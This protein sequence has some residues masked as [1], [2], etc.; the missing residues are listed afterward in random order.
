MS[1]QR[2][3]IDVMMP[4]STA[5]AKTDV[6]LQQSNRR[7]GSILPRTREGVLREGTSGS[8]FLVRTRASDAARVQ[9]LGWTAESDASPYLRQPVDILLIEPKQH[10]SVAMQWQQSR[11]FRNP[12]QAYP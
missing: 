3:A 7:A 4:L 1:G 9:P 5:S 6:A 12:R 10:V 2:R 11:W 8:G